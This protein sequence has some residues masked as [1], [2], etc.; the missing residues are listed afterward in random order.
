M[1][2]ILRDVMEGATPDVDGFIEALGG[3]FDLLYRLAETGQDA[4][5]HA[6]G[7]VY[8]H[9]GMVLA[10]T[11]EQIARYGSHLTAERR[12]A[13]VLAALLHD[14][15]KPLVTR[16]EERAERV[17]IVAPNHADRGRSYLAYKLLGLGLPYE[18]TRTVLGLVGHHHDPKFLVIKDKA[19][20]KYRQLARLADIE[21]LYYLEQADMRGRSCSD[22]AEQIEYI[23]FFRLFAEEYGVWQVPA[24]MIYGEW[25]S[26]I[27]R[28]LAALPKEVRDLVFAN[29]IR[30]VEAG[31]IFTPH[32]AIA[33][34][35]QY[36]DAFARLVVMCGPSG[37][38]KS[39]WIKEHLA[40]YHVVS[41]DELREQIAG[42]RSDQS[43]NG[44]VMQAAKELLKGHLR[45]H[46]KVVWDATNIRRQH[47]NA[48]LQLGFN[49]HAF[50][51]LVVFHMPEAEY[52][53]RNR[54]REHPVPHQ[55]L[56]KQLNNIEFPYANDAH[57]S[58]FVD[59]KGN[60][61]HV[62]Q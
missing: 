55:I 42:K 62:A 8:V 28:E 41:L 58:I 49:Y 19:V 59:G 61:L 5:W 25:R 9:T 10:E 2:S 50:V 12:L 32:E 43:K 47:R 4:V 18:V 20:R 27:D 51:T 17:C 33:R 1:H 34:S 22:Q 31:Q 16:A 46:E 54:K 57:R 11:Y 29:A 36:R 60:R 56:Q 38:G 24:S 26:F 15:A 37:A 7:S 44:Q 21:L 39:S 23:D 14:I 53:A 13:L 48:I 35:Y 6:E 3:G 40:D 52:M 30:D 45:R